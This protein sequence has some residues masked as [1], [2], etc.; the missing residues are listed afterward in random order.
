MP[1]KV[2]IT[3]PVTFRACTSTPPR[4][5]KPRICFKRNKKRQH[6][7][8]WGKN[9]CVLELDSHGWRKRYAL[10]RTVEPTPLSTPTIVVVRAELT[11]VQRNMVKFSTM[12]IIRDNTT[13][14]VKFQDTICTNFDVISGSGTFCSAQTV[15]LLNYLLLP[16]LHA[17]CSF[18]RMERKEWSSIELWTLSRSSGTEK[19]SSPV[20][21]MYTARKGSDR[22][23]LNSMSSVEERPS[24]APDFSTK[25][26]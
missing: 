5:R 1:P 26:R 23:E 15:K 25:T 18:S 11:M 4:S 16:V 12:P 9:G 24:S 22:T 6:Q 17:I 3:S 14:R 10:E 20:P 19:E 13:M 7:Q 2:L 21:M 8:H